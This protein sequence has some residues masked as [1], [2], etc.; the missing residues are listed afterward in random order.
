MIRRD[1]VLRMVQEMAQVLA[2]V[3]LLKHRHEYDQALKEINDALRA[4]REDG[5]APGAE[6]SLE[7]WIELCQRHESAASGLMI[8]VADLVKEQGDLCAFRQQAAES[9]RASALSL[10]LFLEALV[11]GNTFV[12]AEL[13]LRVEEL[14]ERTSGAPLP[15]GVLR[16]LVTYYELRGKLAKAEDVLFDWLETGDGSARDEGLAFYQR[17]SDKT[18]AELEQGGLPREEVGQGR[19]EV[20]RKTGQGA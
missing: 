16:R 3:V 2:R 20:L 13:L 18:D 1:Y 10:G 7:E 4:L 5:E 17:Q 19:R 9:H 6:T 15:P 8:A 14:I 12:S 11:T